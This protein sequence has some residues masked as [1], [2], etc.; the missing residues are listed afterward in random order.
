[1]AT[2]SLWPIYA[3]GKKGGNRSLRSVINQLV[4]YAENEKKTKPDKDRI[5]EK[6]AADNK[7]KIGQEATENDK[8]AALKDVVNYVSDK[9]EG[10]RYVTGINC[11]AEHAAEEM[12]VTKK[13]WAEKGNRVLYH[14]YQ[15]FSPG[16]ADPDKVH[17][18]GVRL[19]RELW[20]DR[21]EVVVATHL[22]RQHL[23]NHFVINATSFSEGKKFSWDKE[24]PKMKRL[25]DSICREEA[26]SIVSDS[27]DISRHRGAVRAENEGRYTIESIMKEDID[28]CIRCAGTYSEWMRLMKDKGYRI[29]A[30]GKY[31]RVFPYGHSKCI[32]IDRRW[33]EDYSAEGIA[34]RIESEVVGSTKQQVYSG[35]MQ[36]STGDSPEYRG[37]ESDSPEPNRSYE[38]VN[39]RTD[40]LRLFRE[41]TEGKS[42]AYPKGL[43]VYYLRFIV[44][45]GYYRRTGRIAHTHYVLREELTKLDKYI[46]ES[47]FLIKNG[48]TSTYQL[49]KF[50]RR[51]K[52]SLTVLYDEQRKLRNNIRR[53][54]EKNRTLL[55]EDLKDVNLLVKNAKYNVKL[56]EDILSRAADIKRRLDL[57]RDNDRLQSS[58]DRIVEQE[59][60]LL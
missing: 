33:G 6:P 26:L 23:H 40:V 31:L 28:S 8:L 41:M 12:H 13:K 4:E 2:T 11:T 50:E 60:Q 15:S 1:M 37:N 58:N 18:I 19:A 53:C 39:E 16:E 21:F 34:K 22:D 9:N 35:F 56:C 52:D 29:D 7:L 42:G 46:D 44:K 38:Y 47:R 54:D 30:S 24:Y 3:S 59:D 43:Q 25:S 20:G 32:R 14:G 49:E 57:S 10:V 48:I 17:E 36:I 51:E 5:K 55:E 27:R 45:M